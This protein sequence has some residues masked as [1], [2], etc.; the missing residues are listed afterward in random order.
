[1]MSKDGAISILHQAL[2]DEYRFIT[3]ASKAGGM[4]PDGKM[5]HCGLSDFYAEQPVKLSE[6]S[7][8]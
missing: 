1:M 2:R 6:N 7:V 8:K 5:V 3:A 4:R